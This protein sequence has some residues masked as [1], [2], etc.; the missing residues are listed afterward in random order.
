MTMI[1]T[2]EKIPSSITRS[3]AT[4]RPRP[5][6]A[7]MRPTSPR[8]TIPIP[9]ESRSSFRP[10]APRE[11]ACLLLD[12]ELGVADI[13]RAAPTPLR[14]TAG[15]ALGRHRRHRDKTDYEEEFDGATMDACLI[16][17]GHRA[18][19]DEMAASARWSRG[20]ARP[21]PFRRARTK[22]APGPG[23]PCGICR[24]WRAMPRAETLDPYEG[25]VRDQGASAR[26]HG[27]NVAFDS[28]CRSRYTR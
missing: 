10:S 12:Q 28:C 5:M 9:I 21:V 8:G 24:L 7:K 19:H 3:P 14:G 26:W 25:T 2:A 4:V 18:N 22:P 13:L 16:A 27:G 1:T 15:H 6:F 23:E 20:R 17:A 11:H